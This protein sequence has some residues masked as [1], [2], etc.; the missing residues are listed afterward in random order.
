VVFLQKFEQK[1][2]DIFCQVWYCH[3]IQ[4]RMRCPCALKTAISN[5]PENFLLMLK[6]RLLPY[7]FASARTALILE[8]HSEVR[9]GFGSFRNYNYVGCWGALALVP[10]SERSGQIMK[11]QNRWIILV[12]SF[13]AN[14]IIGSAYA[15]SVF[16]PR[17]IEMFEFT[18]PQ[19]SIAFTLSLGLVPFAMILGG[20]IQSK[21]GARFT[22][23]LGGI[24][25]GAGIA[26]AGLTTHNIATLYL[27]YGTLGGIGIGLVYGCTI[28]NSVKWF[29]D[30]RG[31][32]GGIIAGGFGGGAIIFAPLFQSTIESV[33]VLRTFTIYGI[34][35][36]IVIILASLLITVPPADYKPAGWTPPSSAANNA[37]ANLNVTGMLKTARFYILWIMYVL[38]CVTG[39]MIIA[40]AG[41]VAEARIGVTPALAATAVLLLGVANTVGRVFWGAVS[42]KIGR[43]QTLILMYAMTAGMLIL[44]TFAPSYVLFVISIMGIGLCFGGFLGVFP[45]IT[46][47]NFG[48]ANLGM[49]YGVLFIAFG[50]AAFVGP[51]LAASL[52]ESSGAH[53]LAFVI[54]T[55]MSA[56]ALVITVLLLISSKKQVASKKA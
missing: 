47:E 55:I 37:S 40:H 12:V 30:K 45:S 44:L 27:T 6:L 19:A 10:F 54:A 22:V 14:L 9:P 8:I 53:D 17:L 3:K 16:Q 48:T 11:T 35:F 50:I 43:Y 5:A 23:L 34:I 2:L 28:P 7:R 26:L 38:A 32:A 41:H 39:L 1:Y 31:L 46:A 15:W 51:R 36:G 18:T 20:K 56:V 52:F 42:D 33:G 24:V 21:I 4:H 25:F 29:P 49:N 13:V